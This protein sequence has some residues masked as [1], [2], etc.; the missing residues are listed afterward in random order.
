[1][2]FIIKQVLLTGSSGFIGSQFC[3]DFRDQFHITPISLK[4]TAVEQISFLDIDVVVHC[5]ALVHQMNP[6]PDSEYFLVNHDL[7]LRLAQEAKKQGVKQFI[8][9]STAHVFGDSGTFDHNSRLFPQ[10]PCRPQD[11][12][13]RSKLAAE[14]DLLQLADDQFRVSIIRPP[15]VYGP[16]AKGNIVSLVKLVKKAPLLPLG[17]NRNRRSLIFV[18]NL[19]SF[20]A[21]TIKNG[22]SQ[23]YLPQD[24]EPISIAKLTQEIAKALG[25]RRVLIPI[26]HFL[27]RIFSIVIRKQTIRLFGTLAMNSDGANKELNFH[28]PFSTAQGLKLMIS[29]GGL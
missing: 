10:S 7:S 28:P 9:L 6:P 15:M 2:E 4:K 11:A 14:N 16:G 25:V 20:I 23:I 21:A 13:G 19:T 26:P 18:K 1:M 3:K 22:T 24:P 29:E 12:Y 17:Y 8:F 5:A 27:V